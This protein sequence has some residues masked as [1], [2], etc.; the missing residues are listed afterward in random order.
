MCFFYMGVQGARGIFKASICNMKY[1]NTFVNSSWGISENVM[2]YSVPVGGVGA[3]IQPHTVLCATW[4]YPRVLEFQ[5]YRSLRG[6][7][8][9]YFKVAGSIIVPVNNTLEA[10]G[11]HCLTCSVQ[12]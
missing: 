8:K 9:L 3:S 2:L 12:I 11:I 5:Y 7:Y 6:Y 10:T 4:V 1:Q